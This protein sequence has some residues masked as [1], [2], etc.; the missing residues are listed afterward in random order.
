MSPI[1]LWH[2]KDAMLFKPILEFGIRN[3]TMA[4]SLL[5]CSQRLLFCTL[6]L[7]AWLNS[8]S[9]TRSST[10]T[11]KNGTNAPFQ[12]LLF[13]STLYAFN[14]L[15][16]NAHTRPCCVSDDSDRIDCFTS[17]AF[18]KIRHLVKDTKTSSWTPMD[19]PDVEAALGDIECINYKNEATVFVVNQDRL[20][21]SSSIQ[22]GK[23]DVH[24]EET[25]AVMDVPSCV[26]MEDKDPLCVTRSVNGEA[27]AMYINKGTPD[28]SSAPSGIV[29]SPIHCLL[30]TP[31]S[32]TC[33][34][35]GLEGVMSTS[36]ADDVWTEWESIEGFSKDR[37]TAILV[38]DEIF[39][40]TLSAN[41]SIFFQ[42]FGEETSEWMNFGASFKSAPECVVTEKG[43]VHC[44]VVAVDS[45]L[46]RISFADGKWSGWVNSY[47]SG[48]FFERPSCVLTS[49][50]IRCFS[51]TSASYM[52]ELIY[53]LD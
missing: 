51:R 49:D 37:P 26:V 22:K 36:F 3:L 44:F 35:N 42:K 9:T 39:V 6:L 52:M 12:D 45:Y 40:F 46:Y 50:G 10:T 29:T 53:K 13:D 47:V 2:I 31:D 33:F 16:F 27:M 18:S 30:D 21:R 5:F 41:N 23:N 34:A 43:N 38:D 48:G 25:E 7:L 4:F 32:V 17:D 11:L 20:V 15:N 1:F 24:L 8:A 14:I 19:I 28:I